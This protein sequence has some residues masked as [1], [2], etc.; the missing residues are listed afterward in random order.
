[1]DILNAK[2]TSLRGTKDPDLLEFAAQQERILIS[3]DRRTMI[4]HFRDRLAVG[5]TVPYCCSTS[6]V[7]GVL[8]AV[9][10]KPRCSAFIASLSATFREWRFT[11]V[12]SYKRTSGTP[13]AD[14]NRG[15][16]KGTTSGERKQ[17]IAFRMSRS[18]TTQNCYRRARAKRRV[19]SR[20]ALPLNEANPRSNP[21]G[22]GTDNV[23]RSSDRVSTPAVNAAFSASPELMAFFK[24]AAV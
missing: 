11:G 18:L 21:L 15:N 22:S 19:P 4:H 13:T 7:L 5:K 8:L 6:L 9:C 23:N 17:P 24:Y 16:L 1:M 10:A 20:I 3:H 14:R 12:T 2:K